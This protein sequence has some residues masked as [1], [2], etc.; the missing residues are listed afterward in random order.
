MSAIC[1]Q[2]VIKEAISLIET[3]ITLSDLDDDLAERIDNN[4]QELQELQQ[5]LYKAGI[6]NI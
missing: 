5:R 2:R 6:I 1:P 4:L 3:Q